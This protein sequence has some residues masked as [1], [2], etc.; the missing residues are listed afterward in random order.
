LHKLNNRTY[1]KLGKGGLFPL[2]SSAYDQRKVE[3]WYQMAAFMT[4]N[5]MY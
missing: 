3:L 1:S 2:R 5:H 4:E